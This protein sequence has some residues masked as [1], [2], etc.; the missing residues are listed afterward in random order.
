MLVDSHLTLLGSFRSKALFRDHTIALLFD[1][2]CVN[3]Q[4]VHHFFLLE[5]EIFDLKLETRV[6]NLA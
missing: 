2:A 1:K 3:L 6:P 4:A 5:I